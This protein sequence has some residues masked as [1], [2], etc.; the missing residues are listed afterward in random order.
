MISP[1]TPLDF[2]ARSA[3]VFP[4]R[5]AVVEGERRFTYAQFH[6]RVLQLASALQAIGVEPGDRVAVL[7]PNSAMALEAHFGP[8]LIGAALVMMNTRAAASETTWI[9]SHCS[10]KVVLVDPELR[11]LVQNCGPARVISDYEAFL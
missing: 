1:L 11:Q 6:A 7:A 8:M 2:L 9:L 4:Q 10:P 3:A 5:E